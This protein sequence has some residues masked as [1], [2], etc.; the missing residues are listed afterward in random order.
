M[1]NKLYNDTYNC[2]GWGEDGTG[3]FAQELVMALFVHHRLANWKCGQC[4]KVSNLSFSILTYLCTDSPA[5]QIPRETN[6]RRHKRW[7]GERIWPQND[8]HWC[9]G[10]CKKTLKKVMINNN[11]QNT[12]LVKWK[13]Y[14]WKCVFTHKNTFLIQLLLKTGLQIR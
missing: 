3:T 10:F 11:S 2:T 7:A 8:D 13:Y 12:M 9:R 14:F 5:C 4:I 6:C 1:R